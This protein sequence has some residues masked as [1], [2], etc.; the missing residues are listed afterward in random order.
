M[1]YPD[2][3]PKKQRTV[4]KI[5]SIIRVAAKIRE[6]GRLHNTSQKHHYL[7][8]VAWCY[9]FQVFAFV[10]PGISVQFQFLKLL[11]IVTR[12]LLLISTHFPRVH[13]DAF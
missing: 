1:Y 2:I 4:T 5:F 6:K 8:Q 12:T 10:L 13:L 7:S 9:Q 11:L 3:R